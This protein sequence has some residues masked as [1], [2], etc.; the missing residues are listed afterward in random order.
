MKRALIL[1][2]NRRPMHRCG[3]AHSQTRVR[4]L[5]NR[6]TPKPAFAHPERN[7]A[8]ATRRSR[9]HPRL[10][11]QDNRLPHLRPARHGKGCTDDQETIFRAYSMTKPLTGVAMMILYEQMAF[12]ASHLRLQLLNLAARQ[13]T[14]LRL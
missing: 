1:S 14:I 3:T 12:L 10:P 13:R 9:H 11:R 6:P 4:R 7:W 8:K 2:A 5:L